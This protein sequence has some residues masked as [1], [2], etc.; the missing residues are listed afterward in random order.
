MENKNNNKNKKEEKNK[1]IMDTYNE[2]L[3]FVLQ[4]KPEIKENPKIV[5]LN[6]Y[7]NKKNSMGK[8]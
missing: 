4:D 2:I 8:S 6:E 3:D 5:N 7:K 1:S